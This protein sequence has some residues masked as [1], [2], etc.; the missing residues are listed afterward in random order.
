MAVAQE[1]HFPCF[2]KLEKNRFGDRA[3]HASPSRIVNLNAFERAKIGTFAFILT[4]MLAA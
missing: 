2:G 1:G 4:S 3:N